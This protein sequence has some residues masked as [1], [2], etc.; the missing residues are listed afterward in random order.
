MQGGAGWYRVVPIDSG[1]RVGARTRRPLN[2]RPRES[3][4]PDSTIPVSYTLCEL[5]R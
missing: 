4:Y 2:A 3:A 1:D 5:I